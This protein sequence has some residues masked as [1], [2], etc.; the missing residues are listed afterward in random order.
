VK[1]GILALGLAATVFLSGCSLWDL[2]RPAPVPPPTPAQPAVSQG[3]LEQEIRI[4]WQGVEGATSYRVYRAESEDGEYELIGE[5]SGTSFLDQATPGH[6]VEMGTWYWYRLRA[7]NEAGCSAASQPA[8]G[9]AGY[10]PA[11]T[12]V[13]A[14]DGAYLNKIVIT[15]EPVPGATSYQVYRDRTRKGTYNMLVGV[16]QD[17]RIEDGGVLPGLTYWYRVKACNGFGCGP[18]SEADSGCLPPCVASSARPGIR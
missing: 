1:V 4:D 9:Y 2:L 10:P 5:T 18:L 13:T 12:G 17:S 3:T 11:P 16:V 14:S 6:E 7:C 8:P 15:W